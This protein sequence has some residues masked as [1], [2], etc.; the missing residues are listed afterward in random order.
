MLPG[1]VFHAELL[2]LARRRR[3]Y[4]SRCV[5]GFVLLYLIGVSVAP[6][7][8]RYGR[9]WKG[10]HSLQEAAAIGHA[11][12]VTFAFSQAGVI[13]VITPALVAGVVADERQRKTL[14]YLLASCLSSGE[15]VLGKMAARVVLLG[16]FLGVGLP[17]FSM[18]SVFGGVDPNLVV[19]YFA[20]SASTAFFLSAASVALSVHAKR[21][22][23][24]VTLTY[25]FELVWLFGPTIIPALFRRLA[26]TLPVVEWLGWSNPIYALMEFARRGA[27]GPGSVYHAVLRMICL[28][29]LYG[30]TL[31]AFAVTRL[32]LVHRD[33]GK[34]RGWLAGAMV[35][36]TRR[37][38]PRPTCG[39][40]P[41][42][43]KERYVS[44]AS[45]FA[46][47]AWLASFL[48]IA[49]VLV[50]TTYLIAAPAFDE[51]VRIAR[52]SESAARYGLTRSA[53]SIL[54]DYL[55]VVVTLVSA[56]WM[57]AA[58]AVAS[59]GLTSEREGDTWFSLIATPLT[60]LEILRAKM[61]G[62]FWT[63]RWVGLLWGG[64]L[65]TGLLLG[66]VHPIGFAA[67][68]AVNAVSLWFACSLGTVFS[69]HSRSSA[70]SL[71]ATV[72]ALVVCN[73]LYL[74]LALPFRMDH[75]FRLLGVTP[76]INSMALMSYPEIRS[77]L[78]GTPDPALPP[79]AWVDFLATYLASLI[80]YAVSAASLTS[81]LVL[82]FDDVIDRPRTSDG[83]PPPD[84]C[85]PS[86]LRGGEA[87]DEE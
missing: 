51:V 23:E 31:A 11:V 42:L 78:D 2:R 38:W 7:L 29:V 64:L 24:A 49:G 83:R 18:L 16:V 86:A 21:P 35:R 72:A 85:E 41:L 40:D 3:Y 59:G 45:P 48:A 39:D 46:R 62:A 44:R 75:S 12:F 32:R 34:T 80:V 58:A 47:V 55:R 70:R 57:V 27:V 69:L 20:A 1:P 68:V 77:I 14:D 82:N 73:G 13:L 60:P 8:G 53:R 84:Q 71:T 9:T 33:E 74:L 26:W 37:F 4:V 56:C 65:L 5:Y 66:A 15:I 50:Y 63:V 43:W 81:Y 87:P 54:N 76:F 67:V 52:G 22:R 6:L 10:T 17:I 19:L 28:Q 61:V 25:L 30:A 79:V 36:R